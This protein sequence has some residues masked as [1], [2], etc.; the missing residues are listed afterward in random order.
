V[1]DKS[2]PNLA[3]R[4]TTTDEPGVRIAVIREPQIDHERVEAFRLF[5]EQQVF[6]SQLNVILHLD[7]V[8]YLSSVALGLISLASVMAEKRNHG[9]VVVCTREDV[10]KLFVI[11]GL[12]KAVMISNTVESAKLKLSAGKKTPSGE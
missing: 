10:L 1:S 2:D 4:V 9:F 11:S 5:L 8:E 6:S 3:L 7:G 12:Y